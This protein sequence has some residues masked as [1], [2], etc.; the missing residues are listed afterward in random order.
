MKDKYPKLVINIDHIRNNVRQIVESCDAMGIK[1]A[2]V[3]K[4]ANGLV[5]I[6][7]VFDE[8][9][10]AF[11]ASSRIEQLRDAKE[12]GV[13]KELMLIRIPML[14]E[15]EDVIRVADISLNSEIKVI[16]ALN[17]EAAKQGRIHKVILMA[18]VGDL[19]E[20]F[21]DKDELVDKYT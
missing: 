8:A 11:I 19:R 21:W 2:G 14:S 13:E 18:D 3:I 12:A 5:E 20:G 15:A 17:E 6:S 7:K 4:G 9:G 16:K 10:V 1:V